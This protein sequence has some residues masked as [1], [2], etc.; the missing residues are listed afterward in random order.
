MAKLSSLVT[1]SLTGEA[2]NYYGGDSY[3]VEVKQKFEVTQNSNFTWTIKSSIYIRLSSNYPQ[4]LSERFS[5]V[6]QQI[7]DDENKI[8]ADI[9]MLPK[10]GIWINGTQ[11]SNNAYEWYKILELEKNY[12]CSKTGRLAKRLRCGEVFSNGNEYY[13]DDYTFIYLT[14]PSFSGAWYKKDNKYINAMPWLKVNGEWKR[15]LAYKKINGK[16]IQSKQVWK[17]NPE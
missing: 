12:E 15:V 3:K 6:W 5:G 9:Q 17:W 13:F 4:N 10:T 7:G 11:V 1:N 8:S 2:L 16:W 14:L